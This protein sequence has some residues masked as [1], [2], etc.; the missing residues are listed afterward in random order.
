MLGGRLMILGYLS[1]PKTR[2]R[3][4]MKICSGYP[5]SKGLDLNKSKMLYEVAKELTPGGVHSNVRWMDPHPIYFSKAKGSKVWDVGG[6][7]YI[8]C[9]GNYGAVILGHGDPDVM[10]AV[11]QQLKCGLTNGLESG[12]SIEVAEKITKMIPCGEMVRFSNSGTEAIMHAI[13]IAR[14][15]TGKERIVKT[16]GN[17]HG[18]YDYVFCSYTHTYPKEKWQVP[19]PVPASEGLCRDLVEKTLVVP[20]NNL[21]EMDRIIHQYKDDIAAVI[22]EPVSYNIGCAL[23]QKSYLS[24]IRKLTEKNNILL[25]F[26]EVITGFRVAPGGAQEYFG[27]TPD[28]AAFGKAIANGFPLSAVAGKRKVMGVINPAHP[29]VFFG[30]TYNGHHIALAAASVVLEKLRTG[31]IQKRLHR[32]TE[33]L[34]HSFNHITKSLSI[35]VRMQGFG[36]KFQI[37]FTPQEVI[38]WRTAYGVNKQM[39]IEFRESMLKKGILLT[40]SC[41]SHNGITASHT[42]DDVNM[43]L[44]TSREIIRKMDE[45]NT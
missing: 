24:G 43:I 7:K 38:D 4:T 32:V 14:G 23:P 33:K 21:E 44:A 39:Y 12:L 11:K 13:Q 26:D 18:W 10:K 8:D 45:I 36:G 2:R 42:K 40:Q 20:W 27:V 3:T 29:K 17:Y 22:I 9:V 25:I 6:N 34:V 1:N 37:Y 15:Y 31:K 30:G 19:T 5:M 41:F 28:L 16:E 35:K